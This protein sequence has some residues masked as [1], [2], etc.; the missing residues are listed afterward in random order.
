M[1]RD[2]PNDPAE[3]ARQHATPEV[4][5][6]APARPPLGRKIT[7]PEMPAVSTVHRAPIPS[8]VVEDDVER[9]TEVTDVGDQVR[10][11]TP[12]AEFGRPVLV[13][14]D[15]ASAGEVIGFEGQTLTMGRHASNDVNLDDPGISR[16]HVRF[17]ERRDEVV[18]EDLGSRNG[19][20]VSGTRAERA[21]L[22]NGTIIQ[23]GPRVTYRF[24][25]LD[26]REEQ[27][28]RRLYESST[29]DA[30]TGVHNRKYFDARLETE[31]AFAR[32]HQTDLALILF[33][34]DHFK[35]VNDTYGH[36]A[37]D[38]VLRHVAQSCQGCLRKEDLLARFGGEEFVIVLRGVSLQGAAKLAER[39]RDSVFRAP[40]AIPENQISVTISLG[41]AS[42]SDSGED[43]PLALIEAADRRLYRAKE[44]GRN[45]VVCD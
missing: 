3:P 41:C 20:F 36:A 29:V 37:G 5:P 30:L 15:G 8:W 27:M 18:L 19:T 1:T 28:M 34:I 32:R 26:P 43:T 9:I 24:S 12:T 38:K 45:R 23:L 44:R 13:R 16:F 33:D 11:P 7:R 40:A 10:A 21:S 17:L 22:G 39:L 35:R 2:E 14:L 25:V 31:L 4:E 6:T 42:L